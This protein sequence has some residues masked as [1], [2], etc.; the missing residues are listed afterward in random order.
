MIER[1][2]L[3][4]KDV[5]HR[6]YE[7]YTQRGCEPGKDRTSKNDGRLDRSKPEESDPT[8]SP[9]R[10][11]PEPL[12]VKL[13]IL[14]SGRKPKPEKPISNSR[15]TTNVRP[16]TTHAGKEKVHDSKKPKGTFRNAAE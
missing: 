2:E 9:A 6:A 16:A 15:R 5:A 12:S 11:R 4:Q 3:S 7:L 14:T 8:I 1:K 10:Q 13:M